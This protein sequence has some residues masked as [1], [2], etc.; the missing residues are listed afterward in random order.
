LE[1]NKRFS[2]GYEK[3]IHEEK[4]KKLYDEIF[5]YR[6]DLTDIGIE[7]YQLK[8]FKK[9][10]I[11]DFF[12]FLKYFILS[13]LTLAFSLPGIIVNTPIGLLI[14]YLSEKERIK[15]QKNSTVKLKA[16]DV[17]ASYRVLL[18]F[19]ILPIYWLLTSLI[20]YFLT[21]KFF[22]PNNPSR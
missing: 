1:I 4:V 9:N 19:K 14:K 18:T 17:V 5:K 20:T 2:K 7:D 15:A 8:T 6:K 13:S 3:F 22:A 11:Q 10:F 21:K 16:N 12:A